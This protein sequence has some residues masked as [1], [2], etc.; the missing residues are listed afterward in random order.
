[1]IKRFVKAWDERKQELREQWS[2]KVPR[3]YGEIVEEV[4]KLL[5]SDDE[6]RSPDPSRIT[7]ID[8]GDY[9]GTEVYVIG[10]SGYQP[11]KYWWVMVSYG[12]C[13]GCDT[14][15]AIRPFSDEAITKSQLDQYMN[16]AL[17]VVQGLHVMS[18]SELDDDDEA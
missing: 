4:V 6:Y 8:H 11:S 17:H 15:E 10:A 9:Q 7:R 3:S 12:S 5:S 18:N 16:L 13:S 1:M 14:L 2:V